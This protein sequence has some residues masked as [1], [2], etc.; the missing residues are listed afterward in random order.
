MHF[1]NK[2]HGCNSNLRLKVNHPNVTLEQLFT[3]VTVCLH[4]MDD[5]FDDRKKNYP[6]LTNLINSI[7]FIHLYKQ[8]HKGLFIL[9]KK[10]NR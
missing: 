6:S 1:R 5:P 9:N 4:H 10:K 7:I 3:T 8:Q 2:R